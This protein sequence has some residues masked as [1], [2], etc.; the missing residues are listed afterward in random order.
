MPEPRL[1]IRSAKALELARR[2]AHKE[3]RSIAEIVER[4]L[5][6]YEAGREPAAS[7]YA[8]LAADCSSDL[9]LETV[10]KEG[11]RTHPGIDL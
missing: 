10:I 2:L 8:R 5:E 1:S 11:R 9:D 4:A 6:A 3:N 7:F